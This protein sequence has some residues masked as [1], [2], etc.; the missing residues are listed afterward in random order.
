MD[1]K[2]DSF[3]KETILVISVVF[4]LSFFLLGFFITRRLLPISD[5]QVKIIFSSLAGSMIS[6]SGIYFVTSYITNSLHNSLYVF[7]FVLL[8]VI[9]LSIKKYPLKIPKRIFNK[10]LLFIGAGFLFSLYLFFKGFRY[11]PFTNQFLIASN[12]YLDFG[13]HIPFIRSFS[14]GNNFPAEIPFFAGEKVFYHFM[15]NLFTGILEYGG[16]RIDYAFNLLSAIFFT[17]LLVMVYKFSLL[18]FKSAKVGLLAIFLV[19]FHG[20]LS[21]LEIFQKNGISVSTIW[22]NAFYGEAGPLGDKT[23]GVFWT[24]NLYLNQRQIIFGI[25]FVLILLYIF[26]IRSNLSRKGMIFLGILIGLLPFWHMS[27][28]LSVFVVGAG[29]WIFLPQLR[30]Q[31]SILGSI[32]IIFSIPALFLILTVS[33]HPIVFK[34]GFLV[35]EILS[36]KNIGLYWIWNLGFILPILLFGFLMSNKEQKKIF[37]AF[38]PL[39]L[40]PNLFQISSNMYDNHKFLNLWIILVAPFSAHALVWLWDNR[41]IFKLVSLVVVI[42]IFLSGILN[43][44]VVKNDVYATISDYPKEKITQWISQNIPP[45]AVVLS[46]G[47]IYDPLSIMGKKTYL[48]RAYFVYTYGVNPYKREV[49]VQEVLQTNDV[50]SVKKFLKKEHITYVVLYKGNFTKNPR[51]FNEASFRKHFIILYEDSNGII[52]KI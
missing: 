13:V 39:F 29:L 49:D 23:I 15:L 22:Q 11:D 38:L 5:L 7:L 42:G 52:V 21:F 19:L 9:F 32:S 45:D 4:L 35:S 24:L 34:P 36:I 26:L 1:Y 51:G 31:L 40:I 17:G 33:S 37:L 43:F 41:I 12:T 48:G 2:K 44:M 27:M 18:V 50:Q 6:V 46:N 28:Y 8:M 47:E 14:L 16:L 20:S 10:K 3:W 25:L 30:K